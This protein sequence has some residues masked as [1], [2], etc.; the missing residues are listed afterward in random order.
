M[1]SP[2]IRYSRYSSTVQKPSEAQFERN[3]TVSNDKHDVNNPAEKETD[4]YKAAIN[5]AG[6]PSYK[7]L[8]NIKLLNEELFCSISRLWEGIYKIHPLVD[9]VSAAGMGCGERNPV[10]LNACKKVLVD[11]IEAEERF[12]AS[13][14]RLSSDICSSN[15]ALDSFTSDLHKYLCMLKDDEATQKDLHEVESCLH[16]QQDDLLKNHRELIRDF[17]DVTEGTKA[18]AARLEKAT[19]AAECLC[20]AE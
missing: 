4:V 15:E 1:R 19:R 7:S 2:P 10:A 5:L 6:R 16:K 14:E 11:I 17:C 9:R 3:L 12:I 13:A 8:D 18:S 20:K